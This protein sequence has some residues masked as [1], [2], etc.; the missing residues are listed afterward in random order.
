[1]K[2]IKELRE[3]AGLSQK[4]LA[5]RIQS[6]QQAVA[7]WENGS[8]KPSADAL[9]ALAD[10]LD[11]TVDEI[12]ERTVARQD[13]LPEEA[14]FALELYLQNPA[15][16]PAKNSDEV[17]NLSNFL[18]D[19][20]P[21]LNHVVT[22]E[23]RNPNGVYMKM[24]NFRRLDPTSIGQGKV[25]LSRGA[26]GEEVIWDKYY[27][28]RHQLALDCEAIRNAVMLTP[29]G[30]EVDSFGIQSAEAEQGRVFT[31]LHR[32][33]E[34]DRS[35]IEKKKK[36]V[37][38]EGKSLCCEGCGFDYSKTYGERGEDFIVIHHLSP[39]HTITQTV[40]TRLEDLALV[41]SNC[42]DMIH[43]RKKWLTMQELRDLLR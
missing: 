17:I 29:P 23:Y 30:H 7:R 19:L 22:D 36:Q 11:V 10:A 20:A 33:R 40:V 26:K 42:H 31:R 28:H 6:T 8:A 14:I 9:M 38:A 41:C 12:L 18:R 25:G 5:E 39:L 43:R 27:S 16:P 13:W 4:Q 1:M 15:S 21:W 32:M 2:K 34:R 3:A 37:K 35:I 24:M